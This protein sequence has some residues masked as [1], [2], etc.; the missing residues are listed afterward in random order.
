MLMEPWAGEGREECVE[1][2]VSS[3]D[4]ARNMMVGATVCQGGSPLQ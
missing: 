2:S 1:Y 3:V 4:R